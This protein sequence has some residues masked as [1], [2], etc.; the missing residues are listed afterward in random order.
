MSF[1]SIQPQLQLF[2]SQTEEESWLQDHRE[3]MRCYNLES[4]I[5]LGITIFDSALA[6][7]D[8]AVTSED[9]MVLFEVIAAW[10]GCYPKIRH[11]IDTL[12]GQGYR[13]EGADRIAQGY[14]RACRILAAEEL[15]PKGR[16]IGAAYTREDLE[17]LRTRADRPRVVADPADVDL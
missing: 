10:K 13:V 17:A 4:Q 3:A 6:L 12:Q 5:R 8:V 14:E 11:G 7:G 1:L 16:T 9:L 15:F 2:Q